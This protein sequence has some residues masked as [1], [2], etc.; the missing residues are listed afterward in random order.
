MSAAAATTAA[1]AETLANA[2]QCLLA[3]RTSAGHWEGELSSSALSTATASFALGL[4]AGRSACAEC[5]RLSAAGAAWLAH[6]QNADGGWGDTPDSASNISTTVLCWAALHAIGGAAN[7]QNARARADAWLTRAAGALD[8]DTLT[9]AIVHRYGDDRTF[10]VP[11][12]TM[13]ALAGRLGPDAQAWPRVMQ[14][15]FELAALP[16][17]WFRFLQ[18]PV[19]SY[20]L[21]ALIAMGQ[22]RH[23]RRPARN[24][25]LR[26]LRW[27]LH[28]RTRRVL[29]Q[30]QP[31]DG[32]FLEATPLTSF[33]VMSLIGSDQAAGPVATRGVQFLKSSVR[34][35]GSWPID[36]NLAT[37]VTTLSVNALAAGGVVLAR[38]SQAELCSPRECESLGAGEQEVVRAWLLNQQHRQ[39]H[40]YTGADP[41]GWAW[42]DLAGGVPDADDTAGA[43][44]ALRSLG[45]PDGATIAAATDGVRWLLGL[46]NRDGG[47]PT[48][49]RGWGRLPFDRS[50]PELTAHALLAWR[51]WHDLLPAP[52]AHAVGHAAQR[53]LQCLRRQQRPEGAWVPLWFGNQAAP[54]EE[55]PTYGTARVVLALGRC[56]DRTTPAVRA[57]LPG[58]VRWLLTAQNTD[59]GWGGAAGVSST[60]EETGQAVQA[61]AAASAHSGVAD[62]GDAIVTALDRGARWLVQAT[63]GGRRFPAAPIGLYFARLWY[64]ERLYPLIMTVAALGGLRRP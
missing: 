2:R 20:A 61:L 23:F 11:I 25:L 33:V 35:D 58:G 40:R 42:T 10:S 41:G 13:C 7:V 45:E 3:A 4:Y 34:A 9:Q 12:L 51:A 54:H 36:T 47:I 49:C 44:I 53:A 28:G 60:I 18:L 8:P 37:W 29:E 17:F 64:A 14:L 27:A 62:R 21:P 39:R 55:N 5:R 32:G 16:Q 48:F 30:I 24:P 22:V 38:S 59:G 1:V 26:G 15:P 31:P 57:L 50:A 6:H 63:Q 43:L 46:Q 56:C 19:V 52:L